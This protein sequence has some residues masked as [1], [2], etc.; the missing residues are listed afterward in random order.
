MKPHIPFQLIFLL[1]S[2]LPLSVEAAIEL[3]ATDKPLVELMALVI[4]GIGIFLVGIHYAADHLQQMAGGYFE[5]LIK[6]LISHRLGTLGIGILTGLITQSGKAAAFILADLVQVRLLT[7]QQAGIMVF[8]ANFGCALIMFA[9]MLSI[10]VFA[11][12]VL[13]VT[14]LGMTFHFPKKLVQTYAILFGLAMI[15]Y[16]LFL[17]KEGTAGV[18]SASWVP[19][20]LVYFHSTYLLSFAGGLLLTL[21]IQSNLATMLITIALV[22]SNLLNLP[23]AAMLMFGAQ[24]GNGLLTWI[25]SFHSKGKGRQ[26]VAAQIAFD[27]IATL[28]FVSLFMLEIYLHLPLLLTLIQAMSPDTGVQALLLALIFQFSSALLLS[29]LREPVFNRIELFFPPSMSEKLAE[30][31]FLHARASESPETGILLIEMEQHRLLR[32]LPQYLD[33]ARTGTNTKHQIP[34]SDYHAAFL[35]IAQQINQTLSIISRQNLNQQLAESLISITKIQE[36]LSTLENYLFIIST[37]IRGYRKDDKARVFGSSVLESVDFLVLS[38][39]D[40][41][42]SDDQQDHKLLAC[43]THDRAEMMAGMRKAYF[44]ADQG[45]SNEARGFVLDITML[46][47][48]IVKTLSRYGETLESSLNLRKQSSSPL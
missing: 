28:A 12:L 26:V 6:K 15:M 44:Q 2:I 29:A 30:A 10:K 31:E 46:L 38:V 45:L 22:S 11:L 35:A 36:Q 39:I 37:Q 33:Y 18:V 42:E 9:S 34:T 25:F 14:A 16:G 3:T 48:N 23:E 17:V 47:E 24:A 21:L 41:L 7:S 43:L 19:A 1:I 40:A 20:F 4:G 13:G 32:R 8:W 5:Q 27:I